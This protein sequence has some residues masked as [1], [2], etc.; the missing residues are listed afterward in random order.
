MNN[1]LR[2]IKEI[3]GDESRVIVPTTMVVHHRLLGRKM[4]HRFAGFI[5]TGQNK[6]GDYVTLPIIPEHQRGV[7][8]RRLKCLEMEVTFSPQDVDGKH[9]V[10]G[11]A[12]PE[13][14]YPPGWDYDLEKLVMPD[15]SHIEI[16]KIK[17]DRYMYSY[18]S[19]LFYH[20]TSALF[21]LY[22]KKKAV[23]TGGIVYI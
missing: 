15:G 5:V 14:N 21:Y 20:R 2:D 19:L 17:E 6:H 3:R 12:F 11:R 23:Q 16:E 22:D 13:L 1:K 4:D 8:A 18:D 10:W 9:Y 7:P